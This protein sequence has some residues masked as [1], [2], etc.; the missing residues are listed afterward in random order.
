M[1]IIQEGANQSAAVPIFQRL[2]RWLINVCTIV[3]KDLKTFSRTRAYP[4]FRIQKGLRGVPW[5]CYYWHQGGQRTGD[6]IQL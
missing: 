4:S 2:F 6:L 1:F 5:L 3:L